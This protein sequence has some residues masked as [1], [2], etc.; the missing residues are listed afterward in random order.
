MRKRGEK[1][2]EVVDLALL[3]NVVRHGDAFSWARQISTKSVKMS[4]QRTTATSSIEF[5]ILN[6]KYNFSG[7]TPLVIN[8]APL[9]NTGILSHLGAK[10]R[11]WADRQAEAGCYSWAALSSND[12]KTR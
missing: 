8:Y 9:T 4:Y 2:E 12:S 3:R 6:K 1:E 5:Y 11:D 7:G 10:L